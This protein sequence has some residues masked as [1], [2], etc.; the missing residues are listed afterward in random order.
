MLAAY[1]YLRTEAA[2]AGRRL[3]FAD[4]EILKP[5]DANLLLVL[6]CIRCRWH[7][8]RS[9]RETPRGLRAWL[10]L[11]AVARA[12]FRRR[13]GRPDP[14]VARDVL[15]R[16]SAYGSIYYCLAGIHCAHAAAGVLRARL[17][18]ERWRA[19]D[20][21]SAMSPLDVVSLYWFFVASSR[22]SCS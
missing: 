12:R 4:P 1:F 10:A 19:I 6:S 16:D 21:A 11:T 22:C 14:A 17:A 3:R 2:R 8:G 20:R 7:H 15:A 5:W 18:R 9:M 13:P